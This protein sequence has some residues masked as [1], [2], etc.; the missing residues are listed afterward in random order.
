MLLMAAAASVTWGRYVPSEAK[1]LG[2][3]RKFNA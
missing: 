3:E 2:T 1:S